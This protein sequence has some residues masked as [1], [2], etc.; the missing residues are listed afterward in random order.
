M[1]M[2]FA[3]VLLAATA[4]ASQAQTVNGL[5]IG[6]GIGGTLMN[7]T[8][9]RR[10]PTGFFGQGNGSQFSYNTG[11]VGQGAV[12]W[13]FGNGVR[14]ELEGYY[15]RPSLDNVTLFGNGSF[16]GGLVSRDGRAQVYGFMA[17]AYYDFD[18]T[19]L[20]PFFRYFQP[21]V[22]AGVGFAYSEF[23]GIRTDAFG[24][25]RTSLEGTGRS[26]AY[27]VMLGAAVPLEYVAPGLSFTAEYRYFGAGAPRLGVRT[28]TIPTNNQPAFLLADLNR[29]VS[30]GIGSHNV[31]VGLRYAF[32]TPS[33]AP[34]AAP[35]ALGFALPQFRQ[36][37]AQP[38]NFAVYFPLSSSNLDGAARGTVSQA[39]QTA[40]SAGSSGLDVV[41]SADGASNAS[42]RALSARRA[43]IVVAE[44]VRQGIPRNAISVSSVGGTG[45]VEAQ[46]RRVDIILR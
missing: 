3:L 18:L 5:Y 24:S 12:G 21:Y 40:R 14:A 37:Q 2:Q 31:T 35:V 46:S 13:G 11:V 27:Q 10:A 38:Q 26:V 29:N 20:G 43:Q 15:R 42:N 8:I 23:R 9:N 19:A 39:A 45:P 36:Q 33:S 41:G 16:S 4:V 22:G 6:A 25:L 44:L 17:N 28:T 7:D 32:N 1:R 30:P 34:V